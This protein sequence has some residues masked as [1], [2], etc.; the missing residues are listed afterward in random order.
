M[1]Y[2]FL[3]NILYFLLVVNGKQVNTRVCRLYY[4]IE[5]D[6]SQSA[7]FTPTFAFYAS[8]LSSSTN[9]SRDFRFLPANCPSWAS[10]KPFV[11]VSVIKAFSASASVEDVT[12]L[13]IVTPFIAPRIFFKL[14]RR[15]TSSIFNTICVILLLLI[16]PLQNYKKMSEMQNKTMEIRRMTWVE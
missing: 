15:L 14:G 16:I 11:I 8:A 13:S 12:I 5:S 6:D 4:H 9:A 1:V 2:I 10:L 3:R 7:T